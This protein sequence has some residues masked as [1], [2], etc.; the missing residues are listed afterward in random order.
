MGQLMERRERSLHAFWR[1]IQRCYCPKTE[2]LGDSYTRIVEVVIKG[3]KQ[4]NNNMTL[5]QRH[6]VRLLCLK[7]QCSCQTTYTRP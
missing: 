1:Q 5:P 6:Y 7:Y 2:E 3:I 4:K